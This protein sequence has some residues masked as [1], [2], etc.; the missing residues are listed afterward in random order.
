MALS[1]QY[2]CLAILQVTFLFTD[3]VINSFGILVASQTLIAFLVISILQDVVVLALLM[4]LFLGFFNTYVFTVGLFKV[5]L[6]KFMWTLLIGGT[7]FVI[8]V[9]FQAVIFG[10]HWNAT[11]SLLWSPP[12]QTV[13]SVHKLLAIIFYYFYKRTIYRLSDKKLYTHSLWV[14][15]QMMKFS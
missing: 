8:T 2:G 12:V 7:Y 4:M 1:N 13:Y 10:I 14:R 5:I 15:N 11:T 9:I 6:K 3:V